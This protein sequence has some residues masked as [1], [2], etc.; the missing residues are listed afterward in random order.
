MC[1]Y[2]GS[3]YLSAQLESIAAQT[4]LPDELVVCDDASSDET[5]EILERFRTSAPF[6]VRLEVNKSNSGST[7]NFEK[8]IGLCR[9][10][11][12]ALAD[13]D[14]VW[15]ARKLETIE[16]EFQSKPDV[17]VVFS[18]AELVDE[19]LQPLGMRLWTSIG[20]DEAARRELKSE[21]GLN[22]LLPG[23]TVTGATMAFR[24]RFRSLALPIPDDVPMIHDGWIAAVIGTVADISFIEE[25]LVK[26]RQHEKQQIGAPKPSTRQQPK[27]VE[28]LREAM[29]RTNPFDR[30]ISI[31]ETVRTRLVERREVFDGTAALRSLD[32]RIYHFRARTEL[33]ENKIKRLPVVLRELTSRRYHHYSNGLHSAVKDLL[34]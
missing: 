29:N 2:N 32:K 24:L 30:M 11:M 9:G 28:G 7:K 26:Y 23:W 33:P 12:I 16:K 18:D 22:V 20:F 1:T 21:R 8:A 15:L 4:R 14:D 25:P 10:E 17:G 13:Q 6:P 31:A 34:T 27:G 5:V 3:R 19:D